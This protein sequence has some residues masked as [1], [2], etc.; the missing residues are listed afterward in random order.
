MKPIMNS[1]EKY[2]GQKDS[3]NMQK[4]SIIFQKNST[5]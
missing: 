4:N 3:V 2:Q 5:V 1:S